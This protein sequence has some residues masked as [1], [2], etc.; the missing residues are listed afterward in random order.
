MMLDVLFEKKYLFGTSLGYVLG[1]NIS[2]NNI[3]LFLSLD[4]LIV[5]M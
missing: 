4:V 3:I 5:K 2:F 1:E